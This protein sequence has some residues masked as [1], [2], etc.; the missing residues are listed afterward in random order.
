M[1]KQPLLCNV[2]LILLLS[3]VVSSCNKEKQLERK[4]HKTIENYIAKDL[5]KG[6]QLDSIVIL[7][8]DSVSDF[9]F[10]KYIIKPVIDNRIEELSFINFHLSDSTIEDLQI[11]QNNERKI[12][13]LIDK[14]TG[15]ETQLNN[16]Q[17]D[18]NNLKYYFVSVKVHTTVS[19]QA[20]QEYYGF[21]ITP[22]FQIYE[23]KDILEE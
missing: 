8:I 4:L 10:V 18:S 13:E 1:K 7:K 3:V 19:Q 14:I 17:L 11:K 20:L 21:P 16:N 23:I 22:D 15:Y 5:K 6:E 9:H 12:N 2:F